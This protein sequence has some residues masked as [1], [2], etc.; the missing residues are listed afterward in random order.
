M[1]FLTV[2]SISRPIP[3]LALQTETGLLA[4]APSH[5]GRIPADLR[6]LIEAGPEAMRRAAAIISDMGDPL[7]EME[8]S[9]LPPIINPGKIICVGLNYFDH[10]VES[11]VA[12]PDYPTLFLRVAASIVGHQCAIVRPAASSMMDYEGELVA[13]IGT[14]GRNIA[15]RDALKHVVG[16]S[17][18]NEGSIRDFQ[19]KTSQWTMGKN[20]DSSGSVGPVFVSAEE[21]PEGGA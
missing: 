9:Y 21:L 2:N 5:K 14:R 16:Y 20:F 15:R 10:S 11:N 1:R 13:Y 18:G 3:S 6:S 12:Q 7:D 8:I 17:I 4:L 19:F